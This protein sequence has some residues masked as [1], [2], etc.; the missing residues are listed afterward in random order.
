MGRSTHVVVVG[1]AIAVIVGGVVACATRPDG[2]R[3]TTQP[4]S[5]LKGP[6]AQFVIP[7]GGSPGS[8]YEVKVR[9]STMPKVLVRDL[10]AG[11]PEATL[12]PQSGTEA[13]PGSWTYDMHAGDVDQ[14]VMMSC[15]NSDETDRY[16][17]DRPAL[18]PGPTYDNYGAWR[19]GAVTTVIGTDC[20]KGTEA[21]VSLSGQR[22]YTQIMKAPIDKFG[23]WGVWIPD[24]ASAG[25]ITAT[26]TCGDVTYE[27]LVIPR[28]ARP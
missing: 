14:K 1:F 26:A 16:N 18:F 23:N 5:A 25:D 24:S 6:P 20:P 9:C 4:H 21:S 12:V 7:D 19:P 27:P 22:G 28:N 13:N 15:G 2:T 11:P 17:V 3:R 10:Q 8:S